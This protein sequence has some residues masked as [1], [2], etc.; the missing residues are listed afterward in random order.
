MLG[1]SKA[2]SSDTTVLPVH[3]EAAE[4]RQK[5]ERIR[6]A[7][8]LHAFLIHEAQN[9]HAWKADGSAGCIQTEKRRTVRACHDEAKNDAIVDLDYFLCTDTGVWKGG[10]D[11]G[12]VSLHTV[13]TR[14]DSVIPVEDDVLGI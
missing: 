10:S 6:Y 12:I 2:R 11:P 8:T 3:R 9:G 13:E 5:R 4:L 1:T 14:F 7:P